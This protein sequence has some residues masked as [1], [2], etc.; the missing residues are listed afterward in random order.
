MI[1]KQSYESP[2][3]YWTSMEADGAV[4]LLTAGVRQVEFRGR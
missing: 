4:F 2:Q 1:S 3:E